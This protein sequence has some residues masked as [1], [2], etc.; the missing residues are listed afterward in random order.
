MWVFLPPY[1]PFSCPRCTLISKAER[2]ITP[3]HFTRRHPAVFTLESPARRNPECT[4]SLHQQS[5]LS[6]RRQPSHDLNSGPLSS[7]P[8]CLPI[9][10]CLLLLWEQLHVPD[11]KG[12]WAS[13]EYFSTLANHI[14]TRCMNIIFMTKIAFPPWVQ[15]R[16]LCTCYF[17]KER[18]FRDAITQFAASKGDHRHMC[19]SKHLSYSFLA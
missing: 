10:H 4:L 15:H 8:P 17:P 19:T 13:Q 3:G 18:V 12:G 14:P 9:L 5:T 7:K 6:N 11:P 16:H 2:L 1:L